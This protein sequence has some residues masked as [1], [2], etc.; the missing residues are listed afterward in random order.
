M[1]RAEASESTTPS[2]G[3]VL[4]NALT[5]TSA[6][7][8]SRG[9][10]VANDRGR[11]GRTARAGSPAAGEPAGR[12]KCVV[13]SGTLIAPRLVLTAAHVVFD[14]QSGRPLVDVVAGPAEWERLPAARVVWP[15]AYAH[16][17]DPAALD[18]A[19]LEVTDPGWQPPV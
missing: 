7:T 13:G 6:V 19:L 18:V 2:S 3:T 17:E 9:I 10:P 11:G 8:W 12:E 4:T 1:P 16:S 5:L 14:Q 15:D